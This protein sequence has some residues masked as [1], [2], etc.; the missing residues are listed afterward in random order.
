ME[1]V[2]CNLCGSSRA[3][4]YIS[5][6]DL[7]LER[8]DISA[9]FV[10]CQQCG[11]VFQNPRPT[12]LEIGEHY[13]LRY[14][15]YNDVAA[16]TTNPL[17]TQAIQYGM[18]KRC[19]FVT[20]HRAQGRVLDIGCAAGT[21]LGAMHALG[22]WDVCGVEINQEIARRTSQQYHFE[23]FAGTVEDA[24]FPD[25]HFDAVT[26]W[27]VLEHLHDP[28]HA[29]QEIYR[30]LKPGGVVVI[31]VPNLA[32]WDAKF[33]GKDWIGWDAPRHLYV[34]TPKTLTQMI[35]KAG[36]EFVEHSCRLGSY[37]TFVMSVRTWMTAHDYS[38][39]TRKKA[40]NLLYHP[41]TRILS[42]PLFQIPSL[43][44]RGPSLITTARKPLV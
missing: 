39:A 36:L 15:L 11:L 16:T 32:S 4:H 24:A 21:F 28:R 9:A 29:L 35:E 30:I 10:R 38:P 25:Q 42:A 12:M 14:E 26:L 34:F 43:L 31:R 13:P 19:R 8:L 5:A 18:Q 22:N 33:F 44:L 37:M 17:T 23:V 1:S 6:Q 3:S 27:D 2:N 20:R 41:L 40:A 7:L